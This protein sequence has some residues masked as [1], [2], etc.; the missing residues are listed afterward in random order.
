MRWRHLIII[1][2][3]ILLSGCINF[4]EKKYQCSIKETSAETHQQLNILFLGTNLIVENNIPKIIGKLAKSMGDSLF[5]LIMAPYDYD[6]ERHFADKS[7]SSM[8]ND[9]KWDYIVMQES[10]WRI[11]LPPSMADTMSFR[12]ADSLNTI[13]KENNPQA[14]LIIYLTN[15]FSNGVGAIDKNWAINDPEV[16]TFKGMQNRIK[17]N[18]LTLASEL[19]AEIAPCGIL[20]SICLDK[21]STINLFQDDKINPTIEGSY[22]S[23]CTLYSSIFKKKLNIS[24]HPPDISNEEALF[25]QN[26]VAQTLFECNPNWIHY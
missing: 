4:P 15:G 23:A 26:S 8:I 21:D 24:Y 2:E 5:Y 11:A 22:L 16:A 9:F 25:F 10:G 7:T 20:W 14:K 1:L 18:C 13:I 3:I 6:F 12:W 19:D 17:E